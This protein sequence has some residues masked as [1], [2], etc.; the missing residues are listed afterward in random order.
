[1]DEKYEKILEISLKNEYKAK[2]TIV[3]LEDI[4]QLQKEANDIIR[5]ETQRA[6][7]K[8][9]DKDNLVINVKPDPKLALHM[10]IIQN[11]MKR[12]T[13]AINIFNGSFTHIVD[14]LSDKGASTIIKQD[15][16]LREIG[17]IT[18]ASTSP[19]Y[20]YKASVTK[21]V[22]EDNKQSSYKNT[23]ILLL[24]GIAIGVGKHLI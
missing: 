2:E 15:M 21:P 8:L 16:L 7:Q 24:S 9:L 10:E 5:V 4:R 6:W 14:K 23:F 1:M 18:Y 11:E 19:E 3:L 17:R 20:N 13:G 12:T 22:K